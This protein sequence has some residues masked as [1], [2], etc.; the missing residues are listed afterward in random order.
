[1]SLSNFD[2]DD[3]ED[4]ALVLGLVY[5]IGFSSASQSNPRMV[6]LLSAE[7]GYVV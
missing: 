3:C 1:V 2:L 4:Q 7:Y 5:S 6:K